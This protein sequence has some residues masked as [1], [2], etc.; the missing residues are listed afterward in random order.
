MKYWLHRISH[1]MEVSYPL[2]DRG[3]LSIG[4]SD[5]LKNESFLENM[6]SECDN[7]WQLFEE[8]NRN[9][10]GQT[11]YRTRYNLWRFLCE[12]KEGDWVVVPSWGVFSVYEIT[13]K[14]FAAGKCA[15][16]GLADWNGNPVFSAGEN[17]RYL[18]YGNDNTIDI[19]FVI[20]VTKIEGSIPREDYAKNDLLSIMKIRQTNADITKQN[21]AI[22]EAVTR[23]RSKNPIDIYAETL[24]KVSVQLKEII[25]TYVSNDQFEKLIKF[26]FQRIG[27][28]RVE[29]PSKRSGEGV[30]DGDVIAYFDMLKLRIIVQVK[31]HRGTTGDKAV[32]QVSRYQVQKDTEES[33][34]EY[35]SIA[36]VITSADE[37]SDSAI[38]MAE[39]TS[40]RLINGAEFRKM[41]IDA[42]LANLRSEFLVEE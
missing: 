31:H 23:F 9:I 24:N 29:I 20:P 17:G 30:A 1:R 35:T 10:W 19:G 18:S 38:V 33:D 11:L 28:D 8:E 6:I 12:F 16:E 22:I 7:K 32:E 27:A 15:S 5:F 34:N 41:L 26:Y 40:V 13:G 3:Y 42:G 36:W 4:F 2:L 14:P 25:D 39:D 21:A 37:F